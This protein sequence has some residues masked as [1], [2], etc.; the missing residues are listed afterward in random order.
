MRASAE[1]P[2][3]LGEGTRSWEGLEGRDVEDGEACDAA[4]GDK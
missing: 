3:D 4:G 2:A 1:K